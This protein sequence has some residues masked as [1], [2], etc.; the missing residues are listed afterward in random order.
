MNSLVD[1]IPHFTGLQTPV[2]VEEFSGPSGLSFS[3][4]PPASGNQLENFQ[5]PPQAWPQP[6]PYQ[7]NYWPTSQQP[8]SPMFPQPQPQ[9][10]DYNPPGP[11][12]RSSRS[13]PLG[14]SRR[15]SQSNPLGFSRKRVSQPRSAFNFG[16]RNSAAA[17]FYQQ[18]RPSNGLSFLGGFHSFL[19]PFSSAPSTRGGGRR[20]PSFPGRRLSSFPRS[21]PNYSSGNLPRGMIIRRRR[22]NPAPTRMT[23]RSFYR[24]KK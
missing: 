3:R 9:M 6:N 10:M 1:F 21:T 8:T 4:V 24:R 2:F 23:P 19:S 12:R 14:F 5:T 7:A 16:Q 20:V 13:I 18:R 17:P 22:H 11:F 15:R